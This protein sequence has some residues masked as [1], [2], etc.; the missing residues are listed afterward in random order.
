MKL[1]VYIDFDGTLSSPHERYYKV[2]QM[3]LKVICREYCETGNP[4]SIRMLTREE[5]LHMK[6]S[7]VPDSEI[8]TRSGLQKHHIEPFLARVREIV[9]HPLLGHYDH[10]IVGATQALIQL[11]QHDAH[12]TLVTLRCET[13]TVQLLERY[14]WTKFFDEIY[15]A[16]GE[17]PQNPVEFKTALLSKSLLRQGKFVPDRTW[18]IGDTEADIL[19]GKS[20][21]ISTIALTSGIRNQ[22]FLSRFNPTRICPNV[23]S[24]SNSIISSSLLLEAN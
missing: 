16:H 4:L 22:D 10:P 15:G 23:L 2:Y 8:V 5:F 9:D 24:A 12:L 19:A 17:K 11:K 13:H 14:A 6:R 7:R 21:G 1:N 20:L 3:V 18:M